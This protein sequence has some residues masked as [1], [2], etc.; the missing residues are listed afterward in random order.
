MKLAAIGARPASVFAVDL[1]KRD[2]T[3]DTPGHS[4]RQAAIRADLRDDD[5]CVAAGVTVTAPSPVLL[6]CRKLLDAG[7]DPTTPLHAYRGNTLALIVRSIGEGA[8]LRV[9]THGRGFERLL[10]C[11]A[12]SP[13]RQNDGGGS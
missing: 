3:E 2:G 12:A 13:M 10:E 8:R 5:T 11:T 1:L 9:A 7:H 6:L 4:S